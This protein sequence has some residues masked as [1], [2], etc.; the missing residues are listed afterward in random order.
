MEGK[1]KR[2]DEGTEKIVSDIAMLKRVL[3][4]FREE[5]YII[6]KKVNDVEVAITKLNQILKNKREDARPIKRTGKKIQVPRL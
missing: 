6:N 1:I 4:G 2:I 3:V 5:A